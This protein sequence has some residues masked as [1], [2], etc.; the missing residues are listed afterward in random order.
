MNRYGPCAAI[1]LGKSE[2]DPGGSVPKLRNT[3]LE[4]NGHDQD[5]EGDLRKS[6]RLR[7][8]HSV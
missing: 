7:T 2:E 6:V 1:L 5:E 8:S 4:H 3:I